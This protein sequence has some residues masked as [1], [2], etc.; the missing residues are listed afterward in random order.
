MYNTVSSK[1][2]NTLMWAL[3]LHFHAMMDIP[4]LDHRVE[5]VYYKDLLPSGVETLLTVKKV[6]TC[7][8]YLNV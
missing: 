4:H 3:R 7:K 2:M 8:Q 6:I 5:N 1:G